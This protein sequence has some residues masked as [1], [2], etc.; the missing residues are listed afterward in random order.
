[1]VGVAF[2]AFLELG[3]T[4]SLSAVPCLGICLGETFLLE[5][6]FLEGVFLVGGVCLALGSAGAVPL[7]LAGV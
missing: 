1:M 5:T 4:D 7:P 3:L 2:L 6:V